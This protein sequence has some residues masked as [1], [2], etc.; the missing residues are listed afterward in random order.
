MAE[1]P[2]VLYKASEIYP[3]PVPAHFI[4]KTC[5]E[6]VKLSAMKHDVKSPPHSLSEKPAIKMSAAA[7]KIN[8]TFEG[9][10]KGD[11]F[12]VEKSNQKT[13]RHL[14]MALHC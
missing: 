5:G 3:K 2:Q 12:T 4:C 10:L 8:K 1:N 11:F 7:L 14:S 9:G 13:L 6:A